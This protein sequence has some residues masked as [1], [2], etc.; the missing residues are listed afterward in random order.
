MERLI[1]KKPKQELQTVRFNSYPFQIMCEKTRET[2]TRVQPKQEHIF[3][4]TI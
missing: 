3:Q 2:K 1:Q 4:C